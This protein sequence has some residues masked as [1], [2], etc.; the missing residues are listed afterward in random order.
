MFTRLPFSAPLGRVARYP[1]RVLSS[2]SLSSFSEERRH[3]QKSHV[4]SSTVACLVAA[5]TGVIAWK[6]GLFRLP[7]IQAKQVRAGAKIEGL[8][9]YTKEDVAKHKTPEDGIWVTYK[10]GVYDVTEFVDAHP[11]GPKIL[12]A[13]GHAVDPFWSMYAN[14]QTP[15]T[16]ELLEE[17]RIGN[18]KVD[19]QQGVVD[20]HDP[21]RNEPMEHRHPAMVVRSQ[22]PF[23]AE[24]PLE[25][26]ADSFH[27]PNT[28]FYVRNHLPVPD[29]DLKRYSLKVTGENMKTVNLSL[30]DLKS[31]F[32]Q[33]TVTAAVQCGG[34]R[35]SDMSKVKSVRG[36]AWGAAAISNATWTGVKLKDVLEYA[37]FREGST[38]VQH[39]HFEGL[40][41]DLQGDPYG[42][43]IPVEKAIDKDGDV[44][45]AYEM[46]GEPLPL[47]HGYPLRVIVPGV[48]GARNVKWLS[49]IRL[50]DVESPSFWQQ[51]D[52]K[53]FPPNATAETADYASAMSIQNMPVQSA[54]SEPKDGS[55]LDAG[56]GTVKVKGYAYSGGG[57]G[58]NRVDVSTDGGRT[59]ITATLTHTEGKLKRN[60]AWSL[61]EADVPIP[62]DHNG[63]IEI[64]CKAVDT[65]LNSQPDTVGS[66]WNFRGL[67]SNAWHHIKLK[68]Q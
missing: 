13:A 38:T 44:L 15:E 1:P 17:W 34:N 8:P 11:G 59:W 16:E 25:L 37:G 7:I 53:I 27:T 65:S 14:H 30:S 28:L 40:D 51:R 47:D 62:R 2:L 4:F 29:V 41:K 45:L 10:E 67:G 49:C 56:E 43:S 63:E 68:L 20:P 6:K 33:H 58:V 24:P 9:T 48:V 3:N 32:K 23:N 21:Y 64:V 26:L 54:I 22:K 60:W 50:S 66:V 42:A 52:Y 55:V 31:K 57:R 19:A 39:I 35:R 46:N 18:V 12:L 5:G 61:W 36:L